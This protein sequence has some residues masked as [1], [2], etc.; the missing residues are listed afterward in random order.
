MSPEQLLCAKAVRSS[1][2]RARRALE[3]AATQLAVT[4]VQRHGVVSRA[5]LTAAGLTRPDIDRLMRRRGLTQVHRR[6]YV[7]HTGPLTF[8]QRVWAAVLAVE[9]AVVCGPTLIAPDP[10]AKLI[11]VAVDASRTVVTPEG[12]RVHRVRG[13]DAVAQWKAA[14]PRM[15]REDAVL[16]LVDEAESELD[17]VRLLTDAARDRAIGVTRL[18]EA[19]QR[20]SRLQRRAFV[21]ALLDDIATGV[22]S[23]LEHAYLTRVERAHGLPRATRQVL[24]RTE[25]GRQFR[26]LEYDEHGLVVELDGQRHD[27]FDAQG[28]DAD[29][30]L[31]DQAGG[32]RVVRLRWRQVVG[33]PC[34]TAVS[35]SSVMGCRVRPCGPACL[36]GR[37]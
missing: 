1:D 23:V 6:V 35:L 3:F 17:V 19:E 15:R 13:L 16:M 27:S 5:A 25:R 29:R 31:A 18:R 34:R 4:M 33:D 36:A 22:E 2:P 9:P 10:E 28:R 11:H 26:D 32:R 30:D 20:R 14:P 37:S 8:D 7:D 21:D 12:V 24:R